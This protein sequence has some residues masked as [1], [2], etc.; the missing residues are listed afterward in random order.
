NGAPT[1]GSG[2]LTNHVTASSDQAA[3]ATDSLSI[4]ITQSPSM[5]V[6][7]TSTTTGLAAPGTVTYSYV[8]TNT[9]NVTLTGVGVV[10][11]NAGTVSY[12]SGDAGTVGSLDVGEAWTFTA[13][14]QS[15][16]RASDANGAPTA[17]SG[18]LT[19]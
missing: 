19:N 6:D 7:K 9:G 16:Q 10:D 12:V 13:D 1:A 18:T 3:D 5:T 8:V 11:D 17:G 2:T 4:P 15:T 14:H